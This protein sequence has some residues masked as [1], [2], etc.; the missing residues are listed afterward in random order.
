M[1]RC[2][3]CFLG[4]EL[5]GA[6]LASQGACWPLQWLIAKQGLVSRFAFFHK[7]EN[8]LQFLFLFCFFG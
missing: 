8:P 2:C 7:S 4:E 5:G 6:T 3:F 1:L